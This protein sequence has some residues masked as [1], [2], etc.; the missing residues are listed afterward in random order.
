M[1]LARDRDIINQS[2]RCLIIPSR[3][4]SGTVTSCVL[5]G[6][7]RTRKQISAE[8]NK[9]QVLS[10]RKMGLTHSKSKTEDPQNP[11][12]KPRTSVSSDIRAEINSFLLALLSVV[13]CK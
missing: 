13:S 11:A 1:D 7:S 12:D 10:C 9:N 6:R 3:C 8:N 5:T 4:T 2:L